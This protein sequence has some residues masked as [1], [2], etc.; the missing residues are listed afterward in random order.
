MTVE[1][2]NE[3]IFAEKR[4]A[5]PR[6]M[7]NNAVCSQCAPTFSD[8]QLPLSALAVALS[9]AGTCVAM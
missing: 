5:A 9:M 1:A 4:A 7:L 8:I 6:N 2:F 3:K